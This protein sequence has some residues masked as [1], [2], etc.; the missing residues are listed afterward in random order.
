MAMFL[1]GLLQ[2]GRDRAWMAARAMG[3]NTLICARI[4]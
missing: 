2:R 4:S 1:P 3:A